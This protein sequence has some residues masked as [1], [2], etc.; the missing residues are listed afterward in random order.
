MTVSSAGP[1]ESASALGPY[2]RAIRSRAL[3]VVL[4]MVAAVGVAAVLLATRSPTYKSTAQLL[5]SPLPQD[6]TTFLG[7]GLLRDS[8]DPTRTVQ[9]AGAIVGSSL[10][11]E[12]TAQRLGGDLTGSEVASKVD[13]QPLGQSNILGVTASWET[14]A[15][16]R[17]LANQYALSA[18][19]ARNEQLRRQL[20][21]AIRSLGP[22]PRGGDSARLAELEAAR[23]RGDP[24]LSLSQPAQ[25]PS[26]AS[27][28]PA[29]LLLMLAA[30]AGLAL[31]SI[32]AIVLERRDDRVRD[33]EELLAL[34]PLPVLARVPTI[35]RRGRLFPT[36]PAAE[37]AHEAFKTLQIQLD[38]ERPE[39]GSGHSLM[40]T[41]A[42]S[43]D[44]KT[45]TALD[46]SEALVEG[47][48]KVILID[49]DLRK[50]D[51]A[52]ELELD[53][54]DG[55]VRL[56]SSPRRALKSALQ[57]A[58]TPSLRVLAAP[59]GSKQTVNTLLQ[60]LDRRIEKILDEATSLADYVIIDTAPLGEVGDALTIA[61][62]V[63]DVLLTGR[64]YNTNRGA[65]RTTV[66]RLER[67]QTPPLGWV[68]IGEDGA[69]LSSL[70]P[71][72]SGN[73]AHRRRASRSRSS[74][75]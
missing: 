16:A 20:D 62:H 15:G 24:T 49:F 40:I 17:R 74:A 35:E 65:L 2:L 30:V 37:E 70:Y 60:R 25:T 43:G 6:D 26:A 45:S 55:L 10:A 9:T 39:G 69:R 66:E 21:A 61:G 23:D 1:D 53:S 58:P 38:Q 47:G 72:S 59:R 22:N 68:I 56:L 7:T 4:I 32:A 52:R 51:I 29:W 42:S 57:Q 34:A 12:R 41:S 5:V 48:H 75:S 73:G 31:G 67:A 46:L 8:G 28:T 33:E 13:V 50:P 11:A 27:G 64:P 14:P 18:L 36:A 44:G 3:V 54:S 63:D 19:E 71:F